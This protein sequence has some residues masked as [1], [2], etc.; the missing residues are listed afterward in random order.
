[1]Y[2]I[3]RVQIQSSLTLLLHLRSSKL[4]CIWTRKNNIVY[5]RFYSRFRPKTRTWPRNVKYQLLFNGIKNNKMCSRSV[6]SAGWTCWTLWCLWTFFGPTRARGEWW[7][8]EAAQPD[9]I[10]MLMRNSSLLNLMLTSFGGYFFSVTC[11]WEE[12]FSQGFCLT[13]FFLFWMGK[14]NEQTY[15]DRDEHLSLK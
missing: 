13:F 11:S 12:F 1:M 2:F 6:L 5:Q 7:C 8:R 9:I 3:D 15:C 14:Q 10:L 4:T